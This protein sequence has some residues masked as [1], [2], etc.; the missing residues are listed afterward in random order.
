MCR[1]LR[2]LL[3]RFP[4]RTFVFAGDSGYGTHAVARFCHRHRARLGVR[5]PRWVV[6][7]RAIAARKTGADRVL[8]PAVD[9]PLPTGFTLG[10]LA[11]VHWRTQ[12]SG[13]EVQSEVAELLDELW[14]DHVGGVARTTAAILTDPDAETFPEGRVMFRL[15][16]ERERDPAVIDKAKAL[17]KRRDGRLA[18]TACGF[19][20]EAT[21]GALGRDFIEG[22][23]TRPLATLTREQDTRVSDI[24]LVCS[25]CHRML[26]R[27]PDLTVGLLKALLAGR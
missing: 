9:D 2:L 4:D 8:D 18:C 25:N 1:L 17:A 11:R 5:V 10:P 19:D 24:A 7:A 14:A 27:R 12:M 23:H 3:I 16:R 20:F 22:H 13:I 21:Y 6:H 26:H 15:H